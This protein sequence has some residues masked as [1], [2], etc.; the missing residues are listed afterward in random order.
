MSLSNICDWMSEEEILKLFQQAKNFL[1]VEPGR[2][3]GILLRLGT[4]DKTDV[5][6]SSA[7]KAGL[8]V[9]LNL[10]DDDCSVVPSSETV[11]CILKN[12]D[13]SSK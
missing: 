10:S 8:Q 12:D 3:S 4:C 11:L 2:I 13:G 6:K 5:L 7:E 9:V 1:K